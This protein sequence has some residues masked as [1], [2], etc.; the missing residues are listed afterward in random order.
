MKELKL[1]DLLPRVN[2]AKLCE[3]WKRVRVAQGDALNADRFAARMTED[4]LKAAATDEPGPSGSDILDAETVAEELWA[5]ACSLA[6][7]ARTISGA[8]EAALRRCT[9]K[10]LGEAPVEDYVAK[11]G[12]SNPD[13]VD[14]ENRLDAEITLL[15]RAVIDCVFIGDDEAAARYHDVVNN[16][17]ANFGEGADIVIFG[18]EVA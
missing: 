9:E 13:T 6:S 18:E 14:E 8:A 10:I 15:R 11:M 5:Y 16:C 3:Q 17:L 2:L 12:L 1:I 7:E 4:A